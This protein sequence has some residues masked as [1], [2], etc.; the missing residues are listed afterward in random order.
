[1]F[2]PHYHLLHCLYHC[3]L[4]AMWVSA[5]SCPAGWVSAP[6]AHWASPPASPS[7]TGAGSPTPGVEVVSSDLAPAWEEQSNISSTVTH[8]TLALI[9]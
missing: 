4:L 5:M 2:A 8:L 7:V 9:H 1:M 3:F 6:M